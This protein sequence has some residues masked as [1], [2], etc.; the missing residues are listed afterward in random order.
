MTRFHPDAEIFRCEGGLF[1]VEPCELDLHVGRRGR[2]R[3]PKWPVERE[4]F[5]IAGVQKDYTGQIVYRVIFEKSDLHR[6]GSPLSPERVE[7]V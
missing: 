1:D 4:E 6:F 2:V 7:F 3:D 5:V